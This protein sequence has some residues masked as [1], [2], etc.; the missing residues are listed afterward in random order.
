MDKKY[1]VVNK[2][3]SDEE[4]T[5]ELKKI[6][7]DL[8]D[9]INKKGSIEIDLRKL[10]ITLRALK[11]YLLLGNPYDLKILTKKG[12]RPIK[13]RITKVEPPEPDHIDFEEIVRQI[14]S[15]E[16]EEIEREMEI[17][18]E[19]E[20]PSAPEKEKKIEIPPVEE[21]TYQL[22]PLIPPTSLPIEENAYQFRLPTTINLLPVE[23]DTYQFRLSV[24]LE[25]PPLIEDTYQF[26][27]ISGI[28]MKPPQVEENTYQFRLSSPVEQKKQVEEIKQQGI[29]S[30]ITKTLSELKQFFFTPKIQEKPPKTQ[31][32]VSESIQ[33][34][35]E[36]AKQKAEKVEK[37]LD[38][39]DIY[40]KEAGK[41]EIE[42]EKQV[43]QEEKQGI[44][45]TVINKTKQFFRKIFMFLF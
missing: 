44:I 24:K 2:G 33:E 17:D 11:K 20:N 36:K 12:N 23:E 30:K 35:L 43:K 39:Q 26:S 3:Y 37:Q 41:Q 8:E 6:I 13:V 16:P 45:S 15:Q 4:F 25:I 28:N 22:K 27:I 1:S 38:K 40:I 14:L 42:K 34:K 32:K 31:E 21:E 19:I 18:I 5:D 7:K 29:L 10:G 9:Q